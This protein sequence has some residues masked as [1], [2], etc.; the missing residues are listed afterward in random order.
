M[1]RVNQHLTI[2]LT[3][4]LLFIAGS[5]SAASANGMSEE[6]RWAA[7]SKNRVKALGSENEGLRQ[8]AMQMVIEHRDNINVGEAVFEVMRVFR[9]DKNTKVRQLAL[10]AL[11]SINNSWANQFL[12]RQIQFEGDP[13]IHKHLVSLYA[14]HSS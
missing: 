9:H 7:F 5:F 2:L 12:R 11:H 6:Q 8:S 10:R 14:V 13:V 1:K 3:T 4:L